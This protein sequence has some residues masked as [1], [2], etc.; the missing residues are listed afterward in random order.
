MPRRLTV[1]VCI[2]RFTSNCKEE[3]T[4]F[5]MVD[6]V[7]WLGTSLSAVAGHCST[8]FYTSGSREE[9]QSRLD[10]SFKGPLS[11]KGLY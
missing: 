9:N 3:G 7:Q 5:L 10:Y 8:A 11:V 6:K 1:A 4:P 2:H